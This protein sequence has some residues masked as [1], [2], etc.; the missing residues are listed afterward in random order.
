MATSQPTAHRPLTGARNRRGAKNKRRARRHASVYGNGRWTGRLRGRPSRPRRQTRRLPLPGYDTTRPAI[1]PGRSSCSAGCKTGTAAS[2]P[3]PL[4]PSGNRTPDRTPR[5]SA[6]HP[7]D[8]AVLPA[9]L[10]AR[11]EPQSR[12]PSRPPLPLP[13]DDLEVASCSALAALDRLQG[14]AQPQPPCNEHPCPK[15][16]EKA[17]GGVKGLDGVS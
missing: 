12:A 15:S 13:P 10:F 7:L 9:A 2:R 14:P 5:P 4:L 16:W 17:P 6:V 11:L 8:V 3:G 1:A